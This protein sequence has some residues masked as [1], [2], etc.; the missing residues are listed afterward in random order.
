MRRGSVVGVTPRGETGQARVCTG[1]LQ[2]ITPSS[3]PFLSPLPLGGLA[4]CSCPKVSAFPSG[5]EGK[6]RIITAVDARR[7]ISG[8]GYRNKERCSPFLIKICRSGAL[9]GR[10]EA[11]G[12]LVLGPRGANHRAAACCDPLQAVP[13]ALSRGL[14]SHPH[15]ALPGDRE[16]GAASL[17]KSPDEGSGA[18]LLA[19]PAV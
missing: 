8:S 7:R 18:L 9:S 2:P 4:L 13:A 10:K 11:E 1:S 12:A 14:P 5:H 19:V 6:D 16:R 17:G 15:P 3:H